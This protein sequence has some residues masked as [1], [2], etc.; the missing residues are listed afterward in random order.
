MSRRPVGGT[1]SAVLTHPRIAGTVSSLRGIASPVGATAASRIAVGVGAFA[2]LVFVLL[3]FH[4]RWVPE[5]DGAFGQAADRVLAGELP[6]REFV[7]IYTGGLTFFNAA[8]FGV[9][10]E[11]L[12]WLR[13]P[14]VVLTLAAAAC[15]FWIAR[16]FVPLPVAGLAVL[17]TVGWGYTLY[18]APMP[19]WYL[20]YFA[21][22]G[23]TCLLRFLDTRRDRWLVL[24]GVFGGLS[25]VVKVTGVWYVFAAL[26]FLV[27]V[28]QEDRA[29][30]RYAW[31]LRN[32]Y[33]V[34]LVGVSA[35]PLAVAASILEAH[36]GAAELYNLFLP[37]AAVCFAVIANEG[38]VPRGVSVRRR[39][40]AVARMGAPFLVGVALPVLVFCIP[41]VASGALG[42]LYEGALVS[43]KNRLGR[44]YLG[45]PHPVYA[46]VAVPLVLLLAARRVVRPSICRV[47]D[48]GGVL[49]LAFLVVRGSEHTAYQLIWSAARSG[50]PLIPILGAVVLIV[51]RE[52]G[53]TPLDRRPALLL[54]ALA[55]FALQPQFPYAETIYFCYAVPLLVLA[56][57]AVTRYA[58][59]GGGLFPVALL[60]AF[61]AFGFLWMDRSPQTLGREYEG[62]VHYVVL[63]HSRASIGV[64]ARD[65]SIYQRITTLLREHASGPYVYAG[66]DTPEIYYLSGLRNPT[67]ALFGFLDDSGSGRGARLLE[68]LRRHDVTAIAIDLQPAISDPHG[69]DVLRA[70]RTRFPNAA[71]VDRIE[72]RWR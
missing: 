65:R 70:L 4:D 34:V 59:I 31:R 44:I 56:G 7:D 3:R 49:L 39:T 61:M 28:D 2:I 11:N 66:P 16:R 67:R 14:L 41:Y 18:P 52:R 60:A 27:F 47:L 72:V 23:A 38:W 30:R 33:L 26:L 64:T 68:S 42:D 48:L 69:A 22:F 32:P 37:V 21:I 20:L 17:L 9:F 71:R 51:V 57:V 13:M 50:A 35:I 10:G 29:E 46:L 43:P 54:V 58:S 55:A 62:R 63:D 8:L 36:L 45:T 40:A 25:I 6:H 12:I 24:A 15:V 19:S 1:R 5:D 53:A